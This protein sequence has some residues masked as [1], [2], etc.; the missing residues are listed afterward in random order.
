MRTLERNNLEEMQNSKSRLSE[1]QDKYTQHKKQLAHANRRAHDTMEPVK[2]DLQNQRTESDRLK[3]LQDDELPMRVKQIEA[4]SREKADLEKSISQMEDERLTIV[5]KIEDVTKSNADR[6]KEYHELQ[7]QADSVRSSNSVLM[8]LN[9]KVQGQITAVL[10]EKESMEEQVSTMT[11]G[12]EGKT[13]HLA[14]IEKNVTTLDTK[15]KELQANLLYLTGERQRLIGDKTEMQKIIHQSKMNRKHLESEEEKLSEQLRDLMPQITKL[16]EE[17]EAMEK[18]KEEL[19]MQIAQ[20]AQKS[21]V[22]GEAVQKA[23]KDLR[24]FVTTA[25]ATVTNELDQLSRTTLA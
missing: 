22:V 12:Q 4:S 9:K 23:A 13:N 7:T 15:L 16:A 3:H 5:A 19:E 18:E 2:V 14:N 10:A 25:E 20:K 11:H 6:F 21:R 1:N 17:K 24:D 8:G